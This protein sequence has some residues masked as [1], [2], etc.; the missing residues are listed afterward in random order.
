MKLKYFIKKR[1]I[2]RII[3]RNIIHSIKI[4]RLI[5]NIKV[6]NIKVKN[7]KVKNIKVKNI[8]VKRVIAMKVELNLL[9]NYKMLMVLMISK[10]VY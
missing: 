6:K 10:I 4:I 9:M 3:I 7:I 5:K 1:I 2:I 8:K